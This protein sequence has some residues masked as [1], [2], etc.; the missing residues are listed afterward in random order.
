MERVE[1]GIGEGMRVFKKPYRKLNGDVEALKRWYVEIRDHNGTPQRIAAFTDKAASEEIGRKLER[2]VATKIAGGVLDQSM[3]RWLEALPQS[4]KE[5]LNDIGLLDRS[6]VAGT[7]PLLDHLAE[8]RASLSDKGNTQA[9][10]DLVHLRAKRVCELSGFR[11]WSDISASAVERTLAELRKGKESLS[12]Q[13]SNFYLKAFQ[14][15]CKWMVRE[16]R[17]GQ[18]PVEFLQGV[19]ARTDRRHD[20]REL[21]VPELLGLLAATRK[22]GAVFGVKGPERALLYQFAA[23]SGLRSNE[24]RSLTTASF[25]FEGLTVT[26]AAKSTKN[27]RE[28]VLP[29]KP[30]TAKAIQALFFGKQPGDVAFKMPSKYNV[31]KMI[32]RDVEAAGLPYKDAAGR[33][34]DFHALRH[35]YCTNLMSTCGNVKVAQALARHSDV[36]LTMRYAHAAKPD[37]TNAIRGLPDLSGNAENEKLSA[38][39]DNAIA[40]Q[41]RGPSSGPE[42]TGFRDS[43]VDSARLPLPMETASHLPDSNRGPTV[44]KYFG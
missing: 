42:W 16:R 24:L 8:F 30:D 31:S 11:L 5:R 3:S 12:A 1:K 28:S 23:E 17:A 40:V 10:V 43:P 4:L 33:F 26:T 37:Q 19:N 39:S 18:S 25:D 14:Q 34:V 9:H 6:A 15:F 32:R 22:A 2:L 27:R 35:T 44:Y 41:T 7:K 29:L 36:N 13:T 20:R 21:T 38:C